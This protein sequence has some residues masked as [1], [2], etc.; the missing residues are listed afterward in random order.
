[1]KSRK[2]NRFLA[3]LGACAIVMT[4]TPLT[5]SA[6]GSVSGNSSTAKE[7]TQ[8]ESTN[9]SDDEKERVETP[10]AESEDATGGSSK[11]DLTKA[12]SPVAAA[13]KTATKA[14]E[15]AAGSK[16][17]TSSVSGNTTDSGSAKRD[18]SGDDQ[19]DG[20]DGEDGDST[21]EENPEEPKEPEPTIEA[22][23]L[24]GK[25]TY[26][27]VLKELTMQDVDDDTK[28][29]TAFKP[30]LKL[31]YDLVT[32]PGSMTVKVLVD[33]NED[34]EEEEVDKEIALQYGADFLK[35]ISNYNDKKGVIFEDGAELI[36]S[37]E[38]LD[39]NYV[40]FDE[41]S[42]TK[43][44]A[45]TFK[46]W[47]SLV[48]VV[49]YGEALAF[50]GVSD[51]SL[52]E[53]F[54]GC[55]ALRDVNINLSGIYAS[56]DNTFA[57]HCNEYYASG[58]STITIRNGNVKG[59]H[60]L[61]NYGKFN[62][63]GLNSGETITIKDVTF[64]ENDGTKYLSHAFTGIAGSIIF[65]NCKAGD[66][67]SLT[68][69]EAFSGSTVYK[70]S[71]IN[72]TASNNS[73]EPGSYYY[74]NV[75]DKHSVSLSGA[76][77]YSASSMFENFQ[78]IKVKLDNL[79][80]AD[81]VSVD[82]M[83]KGAT[84]AAIEG[85]DT[86][87]LG[88]AKADEMF[89]ST[90]VYFGPQAYLTKTLIP[91][92]K[93]MDWSG[94]T[95]ANKLFGFMY[96][97]DYIIDYSG[98][99]LSGVDEMTVSGVNNYDFIAPA[100]NPAKYVFS[101][102]FVYTLG[103]SNDFGG[104]KLNPIVVV[105]GKV[106][107]SEI[108][109]EVRVYIGVATMTLNDVT[110]DS[111]VTA[112]VAP[113]YRLSQYLNSKINYYKDLD[114]VQS[115]PLDMI[116]NVGD[117]IALYYR[118]TNIVG[119]DIGRDIPEGSSVDFGDNLGG[120]EVT[121]DDG[122]KDKLQGGG[123]SVAISI[124]S[125]NTSSGMVI[126]T[127][128][129]GY[130]KSAYYDIDLTAT[131]D[132]SSK[133]ITEMS[134]KAEIT[135][136]LPSDY[137]SG[138]VYV[139]NYHDGLDKAPIVLTGK[140]DTTERT[141]TFETDKFSP[142]VLIYDDDNGGSGEDEET[143]SVFVEIQWSGDSKDKSGRKDID[144]TD[145]VTYEGG[146][147]KVITAKYT[148]T[149][150]E[151]KTKVYFTY[152]KTLNGAKFVSHSF[153]PESDINVPGYAVK[154]YN[155]TYSYILTYVGTE[156]TRTVNVTVDYTNYTDSDWAQQINY[157][158]TTTSKGGKD[159]IFLKYKYNDNTDGIAEGSFEPT[160]STRIY[161]VP[162]VVRMQKAE[163]VKF[164]E[165]TDIIASNYSV[166]Q[167]E[168]V[169]DLANLKVSFNPVGN[170]SA[171]TT[172]YNF[173]VKVVDNNN[174]GRTRPDKLFITFTGRYGSYTR[175]RSVEV[176]LAGMSGN[177]TSA[178]VEFPTTV[179]GITMT[180]L[181][182]TTSTASST[183]SSTWD[184]NAKLFKYI[185]AGAVD[186]DPD[187][188]PV[189]DP[190]TVS[191]TFVKDTAAARPNNVT[192]I[193]ADSNGGNTV[194]KVVNT[195][196]AANINYYSD[197]VQ[198]LV[199]DTYHIVSVS[200]ID[201]TKYN[202][203]YNGLSA[204]ATY[205][206][207]GSGTGDTS[208]YKRKV[209]IKM[210]DSNNEAGLRPKKLKVTITNEDGTDTSV[211][212]ITVGDAN[213]FTYDVDVM[214]ATDEYKIKSV[215]GVPDGYKTTINGLTVTLKYTPEKISK[216]Y[217]VEWIGDGDN[218]D[219]TRPSSVKLTIKNSGT[220]IQT[221][222]ASEDT[223]WA[224]TASLN[225]LIKGVE[226]NYSV[227]GADV[228]NYSKSVNGD[229]IT[230]KFTGTLSKDAAA[231]EAGKNKTEGT[232]GATVT[233]TVSA[234]NAYDIANFDWIDYANRYPDLKKAYGY[235]K[236]ALYAHY[237]RY[238]IAEGRVATFTG[239]YNSV[240]EDILAAYFPDDYKFKTDLNAVGE[241]YLIGQEK[242]S[243]TTS[244]SATTSGNKV[245]VDSDGN[246]HTTVKNPDGTVTETVTDADGN[247]VSVSTYKTGDLRLE[248]MSA[249]FVVLGVLLLVIAAMIV[250]SVVKDDKRKKT[251]LS[252]IS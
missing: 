152:P 181:D 50:A 62:A 41:G 15:G 184:N 220:T 171:E 18:G 23:E 101:Q 243:G 119:D 205:T 104:K 83:F 238:G 198:R 16:A 70:Y 216:T 30:T 117:E 218:A 163:G 153:T 155:L 172:K 201:A 12:A 235:N 39:I 44:T 193:L 13:A 25:S 214:S 3:I 48:S 248:D 11:T 94:V 144:L 53:T 223:N 249:W 141:V 225:K 32:V 211:N 239:K 147:T 93:K 169:V 219:K 221:L 61:L 250:R 108:N 226:A 73:Y 5:A 134:Q 27:P 29:V 76:S 45:R 36:T 234:E 179:G 207:G 157:V 6:A 9:K 128:L 121:L 156:E 68:F 222:T 96:K 231:I 58:I 19:K 174:A 140:V 190:V 160:A 82:K 131:A 77:A 246:V 4:S 67:T 167:Y 192:F 227:E 100:K 105:D 209:T 215:S 136:P 35:S 161:T 186:T 166:G 150:D 228:S 191:I 42:K 49:G 28:L 194:T 38:N 210:D 114:F 55:Y 237:I 65:S 170:D 251:V 71:E 232:D 183:Y 33:E 154:W 164:A 92:L 102:P 51:A 78:G 20:T 135:L 22:D 113:G 1:M 7:A 208:S 180:G 132:G 52:S 217:K 203:T 120:V 88:E 59:I 206:A 224:V 54:S 212:E 66:S 182:A 89:A 124:E 168:N 143:D 133:K 74:D 165:Y 123:V 178:S 26:H 230:Y 229:T 126:P 84:V 80:T 200:G 106:D 14:A 240:N 56:F 79:I 99:D 187:P 159:T 146:E 115:A 145:T 175:T 245:T 64:P 34:G 8:E 148:A 149:S 86:W 196:F 81:T 185:L 95:S 129:Q 138:A 31:S 236:E 40:R 57:N 188:T 233:G 202:V 162:V 244:T 75:L 110:T 21:G 2:V 125:G 87:R 98:M 189:I 46:G 37:A 142:F 247:I 109:K 90:R 72:D 252:M 151:D 213:S 137:V 158:K 130:S 91:S 195:A 69:D 197:T 10:T 173:A 241:E 24:T 111:S 176:N 47:K 122:S 107:G 97:G 63:S 118:S 17:I 43:L 204:T 112:A 85:T 60:N 242:P 127:E 116:V 199:N 139:L 103:S 177:T